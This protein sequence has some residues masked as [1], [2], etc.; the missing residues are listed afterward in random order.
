MNKCERI[1]KKRGKKT[2]N[3]RGKARQVFNFVYLTDKASYA[4]YMNLMIFVH[5]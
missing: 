5:V 2:R 4:T 1:G 3:K